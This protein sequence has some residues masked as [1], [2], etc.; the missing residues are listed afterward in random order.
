MT[1]RILK[2]SYDN[3]KKLGVDIKVAKNKD[4]KLDVFKNG[5]KISTIG[6]S[7]YLDYPSYIQ[8]KGIDYANVRKKI[9][10]VR[11][12]DDINVKNTPGYFSSKILWS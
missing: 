11:H 2:R 9:Y 12:K 7:N 8:Q 10:R 1:Y 5:K 4:K 6:D 3:A